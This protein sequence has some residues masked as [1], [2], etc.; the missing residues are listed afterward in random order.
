MNWLRRV[1]KGGAE[2]R[3]KRSASCHHNERFL[4]LSNPVS[5]QMISSLISLLS[6]LFS[7]RSDTARRGTG[8][9]IRLCHQSPSY[10]GHF[11][12]KKKKKEMVDANLFILFI[13]SFSFFFYFFSAC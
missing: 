4:T 5:P 1:S 9:R 8:R 7:P 10:V 12:K 2:S 13:F 11:K 6:S 3:Q